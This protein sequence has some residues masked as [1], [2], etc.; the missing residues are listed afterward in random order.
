MLQAQSSLPDNNIDNNYKDSHYKEQLLTKL[1]ET[2]T[3]VRTELDKG[4][5]PDEYNKA[6]KLLKAVEAAIFVVE[7]EG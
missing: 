2:A 4:L 3:E 5:Q 1:K 6:D 7:Q